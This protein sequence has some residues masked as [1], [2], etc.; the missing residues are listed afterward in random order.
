MLSPEV[1]VTRSLYSNNLL[2]MVFTNVQDG[3]KR[4]IDTNELVARRMEELAAKQERQEALA[5]S[6]DGFLSG[7]SAE[8]L[9]GVTDESD[10]DSEDAFRS[11]VIKANPAPEE[12]EGAAGAETEMMLEDARQAAEEILEQARARAQAEAEEILAIARADAET[13]RE[14]VFATAREKGYQDGLSRAENI[15]AAK[16]K[17]LLEQKRAMEAE[18]DAMIDSLEPR[19]IDTITDVYEHLFGVELS[20]YRDI[21]VHLVG[22]AMRKIEGKDFLVRV[23]GA[24]Y[25]YVTMK[26]QELTAALSSPGATLE[27]VEDST[28]RHNECMIETEGGIFDCSLGTQFGELRQKLMLLSYEKASS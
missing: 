19:F 12:E 15:I 10:P 4:V 3:E 20:S 21:L 7:L 23:S 13:E 14:E 11:N 2:K 16:E 17:E 1:E 27:L 8:R 18:F 6:S 22:N 5:S 26:K 9:E 24:D 28:L 25:A